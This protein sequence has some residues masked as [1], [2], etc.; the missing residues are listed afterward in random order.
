M[1]AGSRRD[2]RAGPVPAKPDPAQHAAVAHAP[3]FEQPQVTVTAAV[4]PAADALGLA[5]VTQLQ[6]R[7]A[8]G[9]EVAPYGLEALPHQLHAVLPAVDGEDRILGIGGDLG[10][11]QVGRI[12][13]HQRELLVGTRGLVQRGVPDLDAATRCAPGR[14]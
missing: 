6:Q 9:E 11:R 3:A 7:L 12:G 13:D 14:C 2:L 8:V 10:A 5:A 1:S 4:Q